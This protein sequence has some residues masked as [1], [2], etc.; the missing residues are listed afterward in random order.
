MI[1]GTSLFSHLPCGFGSKCQRPHCRYLHDG[2]EDVN[3][4]DDEQQKEEGEGRE[5]LK[6]VLKFNMI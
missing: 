2:K 5:F 6:E 3:G 4:G 1:P